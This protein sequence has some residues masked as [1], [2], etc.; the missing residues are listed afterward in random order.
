MVSIELL[1]ALFR[2]DTEKDKSIDKLK[3]MVENLEKKQHAR[4]EAVV[5]SVQKLVR[6]TY[7]IW[8]QTAA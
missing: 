5:A 3:A 4:D 7:V 1:Y 6:I 2:S 8:I